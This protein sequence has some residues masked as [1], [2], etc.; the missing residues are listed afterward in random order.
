MHQ[1]F[2]NLA[3]AV[4]L[5]LCHAILTLWAFSQFRGDDGHALEQHHTL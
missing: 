1:K 5:V 4:S 3:G 2:L